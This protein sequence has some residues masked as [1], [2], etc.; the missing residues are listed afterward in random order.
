L[1][2]GKQPAMERIDEHLDNIGIN[3]KKEVLGSGKPLAVAN[4]QILHS[5]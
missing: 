1:N 3:K 4:D 5:L 2:N